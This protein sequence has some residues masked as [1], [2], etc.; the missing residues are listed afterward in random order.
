MARYMN[1]KAKLIIERFGEGDTA[2]AVQA[3]TKVVKQCMECHTQVR[4]W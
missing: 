1:E 4:K 2:Q 3:Y